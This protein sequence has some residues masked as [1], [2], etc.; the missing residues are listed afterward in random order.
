MTGVPGA[1]G[2]RK[3]GRVYDGFG[4]APWAISHAYLPTPQADAAG[5]I[6]VYC[7]ALSADRVGRVG[8]IELDAGNPLDVLRPLHGPVLDIGPPGSFDDSGVSPSCV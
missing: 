3:L 2:W 4:P 7:A 1:A 8:R 5:R 6:A